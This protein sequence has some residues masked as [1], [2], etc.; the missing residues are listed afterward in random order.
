MASLALSCKSADADA[1]K[2]IK[3]T[4]PR[5]TVAGTAVGLGMTGAYI[6]LRGGW[7]GEGTKYVSPGGAFALTTIG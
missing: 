6:G 3:K 4:D 5:L 1:F 2:H 7:K